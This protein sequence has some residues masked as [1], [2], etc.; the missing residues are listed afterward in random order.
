MSDIIASLNYASEQITIYLSIPMLIVGVIGGLLNVIVFLSLKT[1]RESSCAFY[2]MLMSCVNIG[3]LMTG[4]LSRIMIGG[5]NIDWT[6]MSLFYC[7]FRWF[8]IQTCTLTSYACLCLATIDQYL[9]TSPRPHWQQRSNIKLAHRLSALAFILSFLH[10]IPDWFFYN[11]SIPLDTRVITCA[12]TNPIYRLYYLYVYLLLL[13]GLLPV[14]TTV[15]FGF[16][17][18]RHVKR[19]AY[20]TIPLIRRELD[21]QLSVMVFVQAF[22]CSIVIP[23]YPAWI[24]VTANVNVDHQPILAAQ[25][26]FIT[27]FVSV[28][29]YVSFAVKSIDDFK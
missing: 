16:L 4:Q 2:L 8:T 23:L 19:I 24:I 11:H 9:A 12:I 17:A 25:F 10:G 14:I 6:Q 28:L 5:Y 21:K 1:F 27:L 3:Q 26:Q 20:R 18:Y 29:Y 22:Y 7:K 13:S 15:V